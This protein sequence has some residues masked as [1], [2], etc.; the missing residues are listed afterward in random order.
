M[1]N[2]ERLATIRGLNL[3]QELPFQ[4]RDSTIFNG[5]LFD[6]ATLHSIRLPPYPFTH[7]LSNYP[8]EEIL[9]LI[10]QY[11]ILAGQLNLPKTY[12]VGVLGIPDNNNQFVKIITREVNHAGFWCL[13]QRSIFLHKPL[14]FCTFNFI[15]PSSV[16]ATGDT[17]APSETW[18]RRPADIGE[19]APRVD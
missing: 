3:G 18:Y 5:A 2:E 16:S 14:P 8:T 17:P 13:V 10:R 9:N 7:P 15:A 1:N 4:E 19:P 6:V 11:G 12:S